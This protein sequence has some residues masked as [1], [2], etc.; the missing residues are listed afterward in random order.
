MIPESLFDTT[1]PTPRCAAHLGA[2]LCWPVGA[3]CAHLRAES[4]S[5]IG[6]KLTLSFGGWEGLR[7]HRW[8]C[9]QKVHLD[10]GS[11]QDWVSFSRSG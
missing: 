4:D 10:L 9:Q 7:D 2:A 5:Q 1:P 8:K 11:R 3:L 6:R